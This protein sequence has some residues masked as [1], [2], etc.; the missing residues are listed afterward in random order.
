MAFILWLIISTSHG[1]TTNRVAAF[2]TMRDCT[3][4]AKATQFAVVRGDGAD[5]TIT[6]VCTPGR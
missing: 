4:S 3:E 2:P 6:F 1:V 5:Q